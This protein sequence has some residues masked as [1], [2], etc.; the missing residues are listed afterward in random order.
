[1]Q[2]WQVL[3]LFSLVGFC[4]PFQLQ[5]ARLVDLMPSFQSLSEV[6]SSFI[7]RSLDFN[8][9]T[10]ETNPMC[11]RVVL[12]SSRLS[13]IVCPFLSEC[14][15]LTVSVD[16]FSVISFFLSLSLQLKTSLFAQKLTGIISENY[17]S[18][19]SIHVKFP[20]SQHKLP[21]C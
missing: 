18:S 8:V 3:K 15:S 12:F 7:G 21:T 13:V 17:S 20:R 16:L 6:S 14:P 19:L 9:N 10:R 1:M 2:Q 11:P 4:F 5:L